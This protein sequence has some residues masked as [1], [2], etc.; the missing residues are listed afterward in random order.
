[1][2][3][4]VRKR[5][6]A[7][8]GKLHD[9]RAGRA[10]AGPHAVI[11][12]RCCSKKAVRRYAAMTLSATLCAKQASRSASVVCANGSFRPKADIS[13]A[14]QIATFRDSRHLVRLVASEG[15]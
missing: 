10:A 7:M 12:C 1:M 8:V 4:Q 5:R 11:N 13:G 3:R 14:E 15:Q 2:I 9:V 6:L